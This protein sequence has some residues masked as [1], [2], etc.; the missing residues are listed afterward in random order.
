M[1]KLLGAGVSR[2]NRWGEKKH[3]TEDYALASGIGRVVQVAGDSGKM[4]SWEP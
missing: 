1:K 4:F 3:T 2:L